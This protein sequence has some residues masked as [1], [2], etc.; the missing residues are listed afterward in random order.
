MNIKLNNKGFAISSI[1]YLILIVAIILLT[2]SLSILSSRKLI[3]DKVKN[4]VQNDI[5]NINEISYRKVINTLKEE[6]IIYATEN[7]I[8]EDEILIED[9]QTS[10]DSEILNDYNLLNKYIKIKYINNNYNI[11]IE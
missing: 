4:E 1:M 10:I 11:T 8:T 2:L 9:F 7:S 5:Y 6:A 3:L